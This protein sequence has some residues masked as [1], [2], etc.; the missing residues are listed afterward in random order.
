MNTTNT[1]NEIVFTMGLPAAGKSTVA[2]RLFGATHSFIDCDAI[3]ATLP[4]YDPKRPELVHDKSQ[5]IA[6]AM[7][8]NAIAARSGRVLLDTTGTNVGKML[9]RF[10]AARVAG[11]K[12]RLVFVKCT[13]E[14]SK[15]RNAERARSV[16]NS[17]IE[18]KAAAINAAF[19]AI[20]SHADEVAVIE[21]D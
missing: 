21:N 2:T 10:D 16:P 8:R 6:D 3:K 9:S 14:T 11:F 1:A 19:E 18:E 20:A 7:W 12:V 4:G 13:I 17:I 15:R 5:E